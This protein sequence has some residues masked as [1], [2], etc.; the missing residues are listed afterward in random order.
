VSNAVPAGSRV[1]V[2]FNFISERTVYSHF[3]RTSGRCVPTWNIRSL[4]F[5]LSSIF[6]CHFTYCYLIGLYVSLVGIN[7]VWPCRWPTSISSPPWEPQIILTLIFVPSWIS[8]LARQLIVKFV[9]MSQSSHKL[10]LNNYFICCSSNALIDWLIP[11][12]WYYKCS[13]CIAWLSVGSGFQTWFQLIIRLQGRSH[14][15]K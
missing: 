13:L 9:H 10:I 15:L 3:Q 6:L 7:V 12:L 4:F 11:D 5:K 8:L 14:S 2:A 1:A